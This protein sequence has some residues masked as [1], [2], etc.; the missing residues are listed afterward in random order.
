MQAILSISRFMC[1]MMI[2]AL[3]G[4]A[5]AQDVAKAKPAKKKAVPG[6]FDKDTAV[7]ESRAAIEL[8]YNAAR[9]TLGRAAC[10]ELFRLLLTGLN[11]DRH[12][13]SCCR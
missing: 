13:L 8:C 10:P 9:L 3:C 12:A 5:A 2:L 7:K 11:L 1:F 4:F 6:K